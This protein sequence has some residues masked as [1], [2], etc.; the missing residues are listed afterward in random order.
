MKRATSYAERLRLNIAVIHGEEKDESDHDDGQNLA[1]SNETEKSS[2]NSGL[3]LGLKLLPGEN[4]VAEKRF[5][6]VLLLLMFAE[7]LVKL[8]GFVSIVL[9]LCWNLELCY[10]MWSVS[11]M[12]S[13]DTMKQTSV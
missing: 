11:G 4:F 9:P 7:L 5:K 13:L 1:S 3:S 2:I 12:L 6:T 10:I 8:C